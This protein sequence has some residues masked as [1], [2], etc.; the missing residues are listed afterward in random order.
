MLDPI[1]V[2]RHPL[3]QE[4]PRT[5][6]RDRTVLGEEPVAHLE[7]GIGLGHGGHA[8]ACEHIAQVLLRCRG[9]ERPGRGADHA[10]GL[11]ERRRGLERALPVTIGEEVWIGGGAILLP[12][13]TVGDGAIVGAGAVVTRDVAPD[14]RVVGNPAR[15]I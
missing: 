15:P 13:V 5:C 14:A 4:G 2:A 8:D 12:G 6:V 1:Q 3:G 7:K 10:R 9:A 11:D